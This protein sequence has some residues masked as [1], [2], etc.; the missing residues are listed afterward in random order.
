MLCEITSLSVDVWWHV[1][2]RAGRWY[3]LVV[4]LLSSAPNTIEWSISNVVQKSV[5][6]WLALIEA[7]EIWDQWLSDRTLRLLWMCSEETNISKGFRTSSP[8][9]FRFS[10]VSIHFSIQIHL[11]FSKLLLC[12]F[13][14]TAQSVVY[15]AY[16]L[17]FQFS[18]KD[19]KGMCANPTKK[20]QQTIPS[21]QRRERPLSAFTPQW[22]RLSHRNIL[23]K[24]K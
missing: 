16:D 19:A 15:Y 21:A 18:G 22:M 6:N 10:F 20:S 11:T 24:A 23:M 8:I 7:F 5:E 3:Q 9:S 2:T 4:F 1:L 13:T 14:V 17:D 12:T